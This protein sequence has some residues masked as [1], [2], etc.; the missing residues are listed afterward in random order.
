METTD[1]STSY[2]DEQS[3]EYRLSTTE[4]LRTQVLHAIPNLRK[5]RHTD[6]QAHHQ[7][8][9]HE[10]QGECKQRIDFTDNLIHWE[11][12]GNDIVNEDE[13]NPHN[14]T[15]PYILQ[16]NG[17]TVHEYGTY[18][19][20]QQNR[21]Y[22]HDIL[23]PPTQVIAYQARKTTPS[24][25]QGKHTAHVIMNRSGKDTAKHNPQICSSTEPHTHNG[26]ENRA[27]TCDIQEL[28]HEYLPSRKNNIIH[29]IGPRDGWSNSFRVW[30]EDSLHKTPIEK[31]AR[32]QSYQ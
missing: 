25:M 22:Q 20:K 11:H 32:Y 7:C 3:R 16:D 14:L 26:S 29:T 10:Y 28:N 15:S 4:L 2:S 5:L 1:S 23:H 27:R 9:S 12:G 31:I 24:M 17:W 18:H 8:Q 30:T 19:E 6:K 21:E 13:D